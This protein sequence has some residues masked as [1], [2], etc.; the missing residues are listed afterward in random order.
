[1]AL[2][3][4]WPYLDLF[5]QNLDWLLTSTKNLLADV[6]K[7]QEDVEDLQKE[8]GDDSGGGDTPVPEPTDKITKAQLYNA[9]NDSAWLQVNTELIGQVALPAGHTVCAMEF[10]NGY[11]YVSHHSSDLANMYVS[12]YTWPD[13]AL[14]LRVAIGDNMH[15]NGLGSDPVRN[16][17]IISN[18][19]NSELTDSHT[20]YLLNPDTLATVKRF[21]YAPFGVASLSTFDVSPDGSSAAALLTGTGKVLEYDINSTT[22]VASAVRI[23]TLSDVGDA[24]M[25]DGALT[26]TFYYQLC[27]N[28]S[29]PAYTQNQIIVYSFRTGHFKTLYLNQTGYDELEGISRI[30]HGNYTGLLLADVRGR[31]YF[32]DTTDSII[33]SGRLTKS[34]NVNSGVPQYQVT[35][36]MQLRTPS[37]TVEA[38]IASENYDI[39]CDVFLQ[40]PSFNLS[41]YSLRE[42][43]VNQDFW[44]VHFG[45]YYAPL[46]FGDRYFLTGV[47]N[48]IRGDTLLVRYGYY[49]AI[50][51]IRLQRLVYR[52]ANGTVTNATYDGSDD[53]AIISLLQTFIDDNHDEL[54]ARVKFYPEIWNISEYVRTG[55]IWNIPLI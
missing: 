48:T 36:P 55:E 27:S 41:N 52:N 23:H 13:L 16:V 24:V 44:K 50:G 14:D 42:L 17:L 2:F 30:R 25:Q 54:Q 15:G 20:L 9:F 12:K 37:T 53:Q 40:G 29:I 35:N 45:W 21:D 1:M 3:N 31:I 22:G 33:A 11:V 43:S 19:Y 34:D 51:G 6:K 10:Y 38:T 49:E 47:I 8:S 4:Y 26:D 28:S 46:C 32:C 5:K 7:L 39:V 18:G